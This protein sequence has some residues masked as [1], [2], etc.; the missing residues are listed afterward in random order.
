MLRADAKGEFILCLP[1]PDDLR[2]GKGWKERG[3]WVNETPR[4]PAPRAFAPRFDALRTRSGH[5]DRS[6]GGRLVE[7][8][9]GGFELG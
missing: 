3:F 5:K 8:R 9:A 2:V 7:R 1:L 4:A 6:D